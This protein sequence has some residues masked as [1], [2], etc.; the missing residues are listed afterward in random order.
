MSEKKGPEKV[1]EVL[2]AFLKKAGLREAITRVDVVEE[3]GERVGE[4]IGK[5][6]RAQGVRDSTLIV[7]VSS[8]PWLME[9]NMMRDEIL[10]RVNEGRS[11]GLIKQIV[12]VLAEQ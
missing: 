9:L 1:G 5:V 8:S 3:W 11:E 7:E 12:F 6:T 10:R 4:A 2:G